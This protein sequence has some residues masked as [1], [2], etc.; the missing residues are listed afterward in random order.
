MIT[1]YILVRLQMP[2]DLRCKVLNSGEI[3]ISGDDLIVQD[4][5]SSEGSGSGEE[6]PT[7][8]LQGVSVMSE[9]VDLVGSVLENE[10]SERRMSV[11]LV[12][13]FLD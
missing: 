3:V 11:K 6:I 8:D 9:D 1:L 10:W 7:V 2:A 12:N 13:C 4:D 5:V